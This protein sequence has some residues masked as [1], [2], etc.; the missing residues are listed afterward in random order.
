ME[1]KEFVDKKIIENT[2]ADY[3][4]H[5]T[6]NSKKID[7]FNKLN[8]TN[9]KEN[10]LFLGDNK[11]EIIFLLGLSTLYI[12]CY[13]KNIEKLY[14]NICLALSIILTSFRFFHTN[15]NIQSFLT[16][17]KFIF[18][19]VMINYLIKNNNPFFNLLFFWLPFQNYFK[20]MLMIKVL[21]YLIHKEII[22]IKDKSLLLKEDIGDKSYNENSFNCNFINKKIIFVLLLI[23]ILHFLFEDQFSYLLINKSKLKSQKYFIAANLYNNQDIIEDWTSEMLK[24]VNYLGPENCFVSIVENGDSSDKTPLVLKKFEEELNSRNVTNRIITQRVIIK[25]DFERIVFLTIL[26]NKALEFIYYIPNLDFSKTKILFFNDIIFSYKDIIRLIDTN[27]GNYDLACGMDFYESFYD[28]WVSVGVDGYFFRSYYPY[29]QN[30]VAMDRVINKENVRVFSCWNGVAA[31]KAEPFDKYNLAFRW[32]TKFRQSECMLLISDLWDKN[33]NM[34]IVN[35]NLKFSYTY[36]YYYMNKYVYPW[37]KN[38]I[39]YFYYYFRY[40]FEPKNY[41]YENMK[42]ND[43]TLPQGW[44]ELVDTYIKP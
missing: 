13:F 32:P 44:V 17:I 12:V 27:E 20:G 34:I 40:F 33:R 3:Y 38:I 5:N 11:L 42:D 30:S 21:N 18:Y 2:S 29:F 1:N 10:F 37:T 14:L 22:K 7:T 8:Q 35:P 23:K 31:L 26:R 25:E 41:Y 6:L 19:I 36:Y 24:L 28:T 16:F 43:I 39:T 9:F 4:S 15:K